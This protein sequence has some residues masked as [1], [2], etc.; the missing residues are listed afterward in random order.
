MSW[1]EVKKINSN[2]EVPLNEMLGSTIRCIVDSNSLNDYKGQIVT[3]TL[4]GFETVT[5]IVDEEGICVLKPR[6]CGTYKISVTSIDEKKTM[7][8]EV[9]INTLG[10]AINAKFFSAVPFEGQKDWNSILRMIEMAYNDEINLEDY[11][12]VGDKTKISLSSMPAT[13]VGETHMEQEVEVV[14]LNFN[15]D[16]LVTPINGHTKAVVSLQLRDVLNNGSSREGGY[17]NST[18]TNVGGWGNSARRTWCNEVFWNALPQNIRDSVKTVNKKASTGN[19]SPSVSTYNDKVFLLSEDEVFGSATYSTGN[20]G[21]QYPYYA[22][23][24]NRIKYQ[25]TART[26]ASYWWERSP[27]SSYSTAFC[28]VG[29]S[30]SAYIDAASN[31][32]GLAPA[33][34]L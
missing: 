8:T 17:M 5:G 34:C 23:A 33:F 21:V 19:Q 30:G 13:G 32:Y 11:W 25:D 28:F 26:S 3:C 10:S 12:A 9:T 1:A 31:T 24:S 18:N 15:H 22:I 6:M 20:E 4:E 2:M 14:I 7:N 16:E 27:C 29:S